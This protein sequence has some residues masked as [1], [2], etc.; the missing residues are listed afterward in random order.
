MSQDVHL[1]AVSMQVTQDLSHS[2]GFNKIFLK[3]NYINIIISHYQSNLLCT[4]ML[5]H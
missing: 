5:F 2:I 3:K 1:D 4:H